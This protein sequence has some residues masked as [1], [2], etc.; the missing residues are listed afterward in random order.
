MDTSSSPAA[1]HIRRPQLLTEPLHA[2]LKHELAAAAESLPRRRVTASR[3]ARAK[4]Q[5]PES[6]QHPADA[7]AMD[8]TANRHSPTTEQ[9]SRGAARLTKVQRAHNL[10]MNA[11]YCTTDGQRG[12]QSAGTTQP[13]VPWRT[14]GRVAAE[15]PSAAPSAQQRPQQQSVSRQQ[16]ST[17]LGASGLCEED[18]A[19]G[20]TSHSNDGMLRSVFGAL[21]FE[22]QGYLDGAN[23]LDICRAREQLGQK[24]LPELTSEDGGPLM[25]DNRLCIEQFVSW[26]DG[27]ISRRDLEQCVQELHKCAILV[28]SVR[29]ASGLKQS[30]IKVQGST[31]PDVEAQHRIVTNA[32]HRGEVDGS[33]VELQNT[34]EA[35]QAMLH[36]EGKKGA[37]VATDALHKWADR[38]EVELQSAGEGFAS[39]TTQLSP[40]SPQ[41]LVSTN[42]IRQQPDQGQCDVLTH[43]VR[44]VQTCDLLGSRWLF[45]CCCLRAVLP[46]QDCA[47]RSSE[48]RYSDQ[49]QGI[50]FGDTACSLFS[51]HSR[52]TELCARRDSCS[53][54]Q[55]RHRHLSISY[56]TFCPIA[57]LSKCLFRQQIWLTH[58][59]P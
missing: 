16:V 14:D 54:G 28:K 59:E 49:I 8:P 40:K 4:Q 25:V 39:P 31:S 41:N 13:S 11:K 35:K 2:K 43:I 3:A 48:G 9:R 46:R 26:L 18:R 36:V 57:M 21:D 22:G 52:F 6:N 24:L 55:G 27:C 42:F 1:G 29:A 15:W 47:D 7:S 20:S 19:D 37:G 34:R 45:A 32:L 30:S 44:I 58:V 56:I 12:V 51:L 33:E 53:V 50:T 38:S 10:L 23:W 5:C 17:E